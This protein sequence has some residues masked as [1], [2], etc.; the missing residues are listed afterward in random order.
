MNKIKLLIS[1]LF[2]LPTF[3]CA[4]DVLGIYAGVG[5][6]AQNIEG[7]VDYEG[8][9]VGLEDDLK[10]ENDSGLTFYLAVEHFVP[11]LPNVKIQHSKINTTGSHVVEDS[12]EFGGVTYSINESIDSKFQLNDTDLILYYE[13]LDN[14]VNFDVGLDI[15]V[16]NSDVQI[17]SYTTTDTTS[18]SFDVAVPMLYAKAQIDIPATGFYISGEGSAIEYDGSGVSD[19]RV[20]AGYEFDYG[21]GFELGWRQFSIDIDDADGL[22]ADISVEG[23]FGNLRYHF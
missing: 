6:W 14:W 15:K 16:L 10:L 8:T 12:F 11:M 19:F 18:K 23:V 21:L 1:A 20:M 9:N 3:A 2:L 13:I 22:T 17:Y 5:Y 4:D 7:F